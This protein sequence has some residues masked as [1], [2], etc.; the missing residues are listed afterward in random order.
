M[1][2]HP[3]PAT[4][5]TRPFT[6]AEADDAGL[7]RPR[8]S[9]L[10]ADGELRRMLNGVYVPAY[11]ADSIAL[12]CEALSLV[13]PSD[14][15]ICDRTAAWLHGATGALAPGEHLD[16][17]L[18]SM[19][20]ASDAGRLRNPVAASG[21]RRIRPSDVMELHGLRVTT[22]LRTALDLGRLQ[23]TAD[24]RLAG[25][26][27]MLRL[28]LFTHHELL[29]EVRRF[30]RQRG[31]V[32]LRELARRAD[33]GAASFGES[34]LRNRW[35]D[36]GLPRPRT[37]IPVE[38]DGV[39][40][41]YLDMGLEEWLLAAE[42]DGEEWHGEE[43]TEHDESRRRWMASERAWQIEVFEK[44]HVFG[45]HQDAEQ[46]LRRTAAAARAMFERRRTFT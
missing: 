26:D 46:R 27:A 34:A 11:L 8:L 6:I 30:D 40:R 4:L 12:R 45:H 38:V 37:Q 21:E 2:P 42:Y 35:W 9:R 20:R 5:P 41:F 39:V 1:A 29:A 32:L 18:V 25:M 31:V 28:G 22:P 24:L 3:T 16:V 23:R 17:P 44:R 15:F 43:Q 14:V 7:D 10:T 19:F 33:G 36:A 13:V